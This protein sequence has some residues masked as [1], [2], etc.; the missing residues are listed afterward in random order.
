MTV[1][2]DTAGLAALA[3]QSPTLPTASPLASGAAGATGGPNAE[4]DA[5]IRASAARFEG[6][7]LEQLVQTMR[8]S[9]SMFE[10]TGGEMY[11]QMFDQHMGEALADAGGM[12]IAEVLAQA[13]GATPLPPSAHGAF[14]AL[15]GMPL[16]GMPLSGMPLS[17]MPL[18]SSQMAVD[19]GPIVMSRPAYGAVLPGQTGMLQRA[20]DDMLPASGVA[21]QWGREGA[22]GA[23][24]MIRPPN[25]PEAEPGSEAARALGRV[26]TFQGYYKC[27]LFAFEL[28]RRAGFEVP[29]WGRG[30]RWGYPGPTAAAQ[31]AADG[32]LHG[33]WGEVVT[34]ASAEELDA[35]IVRGDVAV[36]VTGDA[37]VEGHR[38]H[39]GVIERVRSIE[40]DDTGAI[41]RI[42]FDGWEGR[43]TGGMHLTERV[44][45]T[46]G[47][48]VPGARRAFGRIELIALHPH[49]TEQAQPAA[50]R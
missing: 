3:G 29:V 6:L 13:M 34:A 1:A 50:E 35:A 12:G 10:G 5:Q 38:G 19:L 31:D 28:A 18:S 8:S 37:G 33:H 23:E 4:R 14:S 26:R 43:Q 36:L 46:V 41:T 7:L 47:H 27:N 11:G 2:L 48:G 44:W 15:S 39:M 40:R 17:G 22:L 45:T 49:E 30:E 42:T 24:D 16:S 9:A 21:P 32:E 20:A 25:V